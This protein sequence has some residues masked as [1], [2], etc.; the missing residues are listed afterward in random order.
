MPSSKQRKTKQQGELMPPSSALDAITNLLKDQLR[1]FPSKGVLSDEEIA[2]WHQD[3]GRF[4]IAAIEWAFENWRKNGRFFPVYGDILDQC[5][6]WEPAV[7]PQYAPGCSKEC[8]E[9]HGKGYNWNDM[10][11]LFDLYVAKR[12]EVNGPLRKAEILPLFDRLDKV[13]GG[14]PEWRKNPA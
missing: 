13:R 1:T 7:A 2:H 11:M 5:I 8:R 3:L 4:P 14:A 9:R 6:G 12:A 10:K